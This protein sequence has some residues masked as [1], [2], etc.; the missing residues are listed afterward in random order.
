MS[1][2]EGRRLW[3][4]SAKK[5]RKRSRISSDVIVRRV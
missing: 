1:D 3:S 4:R 5:E 2:A